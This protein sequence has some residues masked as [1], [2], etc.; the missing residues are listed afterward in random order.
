MIFNLGQKELDIA[1]RDYIRKLKIVQPI[2][3]INYIAGRKG[4][5]IS[6]TVEIAPDVS[7]E[8]IP[9]EEL[10]YTEEKLKDDQQEFHGV[11]DITETLHERP[12]IHS[13]GPV[14]I[15]ENEEVEEF[16]HAPMPTTES[17]FN[18]NRE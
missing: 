15:Q 17:L 8:E 13:E 7:L 12:V 6:C 18:T 1:I 2:T 10:T 9:A 16:P 3:K 5:G 14:N 4:N 11:S